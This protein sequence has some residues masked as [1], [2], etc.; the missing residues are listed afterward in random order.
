VNASCLAAADADLS[1]G[2]AAAEADYGCALTAEATAIGAEI[3]AFVTAAVS[4]LRPAPAANA[5]SAAKL[6]K[7]GGVVRDRVLCQRRA[8]RSGT[9]IAAKCVSLGRDH[10]VDDFARAEDT[11][12]CAGTGDAVAIDT[13]VGD[14]C[15]RIAGLL[16]PTR[17]VSVSSSGRPAR[18]RST[19]DTISSV[20][21]DI[22][23]D[24][25]VIAFASNAEDLVRGDENG[26]DY[27]D[28]LAHDLIAGTT[29]LVSISTTGVQANGD[30][31]SSCVISADGRYVAFDST[32]DTLVPGDTNSRTDVFVRDRAAGTT[33]RVSLG[34][35][36][37]Q[38][39]QGCFGPSISADGRFVAFSSSAT[40]LVPDKTTFTAD[41]YLRDR[42]A[43]TTERLSL[44][45]GG[46]EG[47]TDSFN[48]T[49]APDASV[50][51]F[52]SYA[53]NFVPGDT[54][55][56]GDVFVVVLATHVVELV[57]ATWDGMA[58]DM[59]DGEAPFFRPAVSADGHFV[60]F[61]HAARNIV[62]GDTNQVSDIFVRDRT[63]GTTERVS[64]GV[65]GT[66]ANGPSVSASISA[67]GRFVAFESEASNL[68]VGDTN[69]VA[70]VFVADRDTGTIVRV[71]EGLNA[72]EGNDFSSRPF[73][74]ADGRRVAY[75]S[76]ASNLVRNDR[77]GRY[78]GFDVFV[79]FL[80]AP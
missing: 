8:E 56:S 40:N 30:P 72:A 23:A 6:G 47:D 70:D 24:G 54:P 36:G 39:N 75:W 61:N 17:R 22:S 26:H 67:D 64:V 1:E 5:C 68:V 46:V 80:E 74:S 37:A 73:L 25:R 71:S 69:G 20:K 45:P 50:V 31:P 78:L 41:V 77:N 53:S 32:A 7:T 13:M 43:A 44:G 35:A 3:D 59:S 38:P 15:E 58:L 2:F 76:K 66:Q 21:P 16:R 27:F 33:E 57:S 9:D 48:P 29:E 55:F 4:A 60:A 79:R 63:L 49:L 10:L 65:G 19:R 51:A 34:P 42:L 11:G 18:R 28:I 14:W 52:W 12:G 62:S